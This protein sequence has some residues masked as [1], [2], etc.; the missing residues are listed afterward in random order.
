MQ[1]VPKGNCANGEHEWITTGDYDP[2]RCRHCG[3]VREE[4]VVQQA[5]AVMKPMKEGAM[6]RQDA[7][8]TQ[9]AACQAGAEVWR[10][11]PTSLEPPHFPGGETGRR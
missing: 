8:L 10:P 3:L 7:P 4:Y 1:A 9:G 11:T 2:G 6:T 5:R